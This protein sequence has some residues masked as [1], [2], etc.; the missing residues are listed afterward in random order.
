MI[1]LLL[2]LVTINIIFNFCLLVILVFF[3]QWV[4]ED[5]ENTWAKLHKINQAIFYNKKNLTDKK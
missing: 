4:I 3:K 2:F 1:Y 5:F